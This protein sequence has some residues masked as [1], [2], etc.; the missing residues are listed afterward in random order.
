MLN[1]QPAVSGYEAFE[2]VLLPGT[3]GIC[4]KRNLMVR[5]DKLPNLHLPSKPCVYSIS[6]P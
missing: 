5:R 6:T 1:N 2:I 3:F 4:Y